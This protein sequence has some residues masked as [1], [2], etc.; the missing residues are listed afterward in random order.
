LAFDLRRIDRNIAQDRLLLKYLHLARIDHQLRLSG[1]ARSRRD[2]INSAE[3]DRQKRYKYDDGKLPTNKA[4]ERP[5]SL[6][7]RYNFERRRL[8]INLGLRIIGLK[9][10]RTKH[11][12]R[13][14]RFLGVR[15]WDR[16][17]CVRDTLVR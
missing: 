2:E 1:V 3:D 15:R 9:H 16:F 17:L 10:A 13:W 4:D 12:R 8:A 6:R 7:A 11:N 5:Q 14:D